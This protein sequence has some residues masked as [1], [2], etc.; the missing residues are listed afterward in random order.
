M[1]QSRITPPSPDV[2]AQAAAR[3]AAL[4]TPPGALGRL[5]ELGAW[6]A[7]TQG[8]VPPAPVE[9]IRLV[10]F[11]GDHG[12]AAHGVSAFPP[13]ITG[14]MVRTFLAGKAG[15]SALAAAHGVTVRVL[16]LGVDEDF[17]DLPADVRAAL[18]AHKVRRSS[19][20]IHLT[21]ALMRM[22][23]NGGRMH[24]FTVD[25][26]FDCGKKEILLET[27]ATLLKRQSPGIIAPKN[28]PD[29]ILIPP[30]H[31]AAD[32]KISRSII[33]PNVSIGEGAIIENSI[34]HNSIIGP[35]A[36]LKNAMLTD[37]LI[38]NDA[39]LHGLAQSL[40]LGDSTEINYN[41]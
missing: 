13:A 28:S 37:S 26:W 40:N 29:T 2:R 27:N 8:Q 10:I 4:A 17:T 11:A 1:S 3:L 18:T 32:A 6:L 23:E 34:I 31:I 36:H 21:D 38:G 7:A 22:V 19:G 20:A 12:V 35:Y 39:T 9:R 15:V 30:V 24:T 14:A 41:L 33:G 5:G 25:A 16:D